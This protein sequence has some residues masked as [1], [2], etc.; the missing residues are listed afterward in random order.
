MRTCV[1]DSTTERE[2]VMRRYLNRHFEQNT[3]SGA[4]V[5]QEG[6]CCGS[7]D[8]C[9]PFLAGLLITWWL[10]TVSTLCG[11]TWLSPQST[12]DYIVGHR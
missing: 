8:E 1:P 11:R 12:Q 3:L 4:S 2:H 10:V 6:G 7:S 5:N 9:L